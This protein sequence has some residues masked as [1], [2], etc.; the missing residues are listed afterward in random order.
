[1]CVLLIAGPTGTLFT[2]SAT[3]NN[4]TTLLVCLK[5]NLVRLR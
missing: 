5:G 2:F 1:M 3:T 4:I